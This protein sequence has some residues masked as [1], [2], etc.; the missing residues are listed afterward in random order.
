M[1]SRECLQNV[2]LKL[3]LLPFPSFSLMGLRNFGTILL[4]MQVDSFFEFDRYHM[5][6]IE[7][8]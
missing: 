2:K 4:V 8:H 1:K 6:P 3:R 5:I 7:S